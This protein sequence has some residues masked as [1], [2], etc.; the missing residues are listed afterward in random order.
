MNVFAQARVLVVGVGGLGAPASAVLLRSGVGQL[1]LVDDDRVALSN[2]HRQPLYTEADLGHLKVQAAKDSLLAMAAEEGRPAPTIDLVAERALPDGIL[3]LVRGH[4]LVLECGDNFATKFMAADACRLAKVP[5]VQAGAVRWVGWTMA[6]S[7]ASACIR[8][9]FED[10]PRAQAETCA[11]AGVVGPVVGVLGALQAALGLRVLRGRA[12][13][14]GTLLHYQA[15][16]G[17]LRERRLDRRAGC[18]LC[19]GEITTMDMA[20]YIPP[21]CAA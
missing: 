21:E 4:D 9:V 3:A 2:L 1:T 17:R 6:S 5:V 19:S 16:P 15:L 11:E 8:C 20:R 10:V 14:A 13:T 7:D 18:P 12:A